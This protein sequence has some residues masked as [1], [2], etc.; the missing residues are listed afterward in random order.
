VKRAA[1]TFVFALFVEGVSDGERVGIEFDDAVDGGA[2]L[3]DLIDARQV[4]SAMDRA[5]CLP[6]FMASCRSPMLISSNSNA[7]ISSGRLGAE[8]S[9]A[10]VPI[11]L[12]AVT[13][14]APTPPIKLARKNSRRAGLVGVCALAGI[15]S[16]PEARLTHCSGLHFGSCFIVKFPPVVE[17]ANCA[18]R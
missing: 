17:V 18:D 6:D 15:S 9:S 2:L 16:R 7:E 8:R 4:F 13:T 11:G 5:V 12:T 10:S 3:V 14:A 1:H